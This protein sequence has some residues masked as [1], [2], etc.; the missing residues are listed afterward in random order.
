MYYTIYKINDHRGKEYIGKHKTTN[1]Q[2]RYMGSGKILLLAIEKYGINNFKKEILYV[3]ESEEEMN[4]KEAE[5]V[6]E[7]YCSR[8]DT[9]NICAGGMGGWSYINRTGKNSRKGAKHTAHTKQLLRDK[10]LGSKASK[11]TKKKISENNKRTN[12]SRGEK[13]S[14]ALRGKRKSDKHK[15]AISES[16]KKKYKNAF[17]PRPR[18]YKLKPKFVW[19]ISTPEGKILQITNLA[20]FCKNR[21][22]NSYNIYKGT[23]GYKVIR[24]EP[25]NDS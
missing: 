3:F 5:L 25:Y 9:Y 13:V 14:S 24:K 22:L 8:E 16:I 1:L 21:G 6:T 12:E 7:E 18:G 23:R 4:K 2:D 19:D 10:K 20:D 15:K 11:E 17:A